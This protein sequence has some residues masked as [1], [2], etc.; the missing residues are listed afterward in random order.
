[1]AAAQ[2][3]SG[4]ETHQCDPGKEEWRDAGTPKRG[5]TVVLSANAADNLD[6]LGGG[7]FGSIYWVYDGLVR[8]R[9]CFVQDFTP[10]PDLA[11]SWAIS[12]DGKTYTFKL[13]QGVKWQN[14]PPVNGRPFTSADV[15]W[16]VD[17]QKQGGLLK[18]YWA[19]VSYQTPDDYTVV[20]ALAA[21]DADFL[22]KLADFRNVILPHEI[23]DQYG[24]FK[25]VAVG[26]G[27]FMLKSFQPGL[28][29]DYQRNPDYWEM[30]SDGKSLPYVD[31]IHAISFADGAAM[32]AAFKSGQLDETGVDS[33]VDFNA[34]KTQSPRNPT[35]TAYF[36]AYMAVY[37][38]QKRQTPFN[39]VR[40]RQAVSLAIN[41]DDLIS[42]NQGGGYSGFIPPYVKEYSLPQDKLKAYAVYDLDKA[43]QLMSESGHPPGSIKDT[44]QTTVR[45]QYQSGAQYVQQQLAKIG[46][47]LQL[48]VDPTPSFSALMQKGDFDIAFAAY[49]GSNVPGFWVGDFI[50]SGSNQDFLGISDP[51]VDRLVDAEQAQPDLG[52]RRPLLDQLEQHLFE[53]MPYIPTI[54]YNTYNV[55]ACRLKNAALPN[56]SYT[57]DY[58]RTAW[59][60]TSGC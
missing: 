6:V 22:D 33:V 51:E 59:L 47:E 20:L 12:P 11:E 45:P 54:S 7:R 29:I 42:I 48:N 57:I 41:R 38:N 21:P 5:G 4:S 32:L 8:N 34:L 60:D 55:R 35:Y 49:P 15:A 27:P 1:V 26:T 3:A 46:I 40:V 25:S 31:E 53:T 13:R 43:K 24:D 56:G 37:F 16:T 23:K 10:E 18:S 2:A 19:N 30:G 14:V 28:E 39:D 58:G 44:L 9:N 17:Q 50:H 36:S 52:Q